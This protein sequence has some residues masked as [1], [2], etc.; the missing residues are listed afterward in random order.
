M[1][2]Q[3]NWQSVALLLRHAKTQ[4]GGFTALRAPKDTSNRIA[5]NS[6]YEN[7]SYSFLHDNSI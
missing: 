5:E 3:V 2:A 7:R 1:S 6:K 4:L